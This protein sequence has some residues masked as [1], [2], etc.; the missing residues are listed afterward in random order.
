MLFKNDFFE[1]INDASIQDI[2]IIKNIK[3]LYEED[4]GDKNNKNL[5][6]VTKT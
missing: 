5:K 1:K 6:I 4:H 2:D 3:M